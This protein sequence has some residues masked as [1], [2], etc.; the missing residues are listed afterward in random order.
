[1]K[2]VFSRGYNYAMSA[3]D[4]WYRRK[5][6]LLSSWCKCKK[7]KLT[8][9]TAYKAARLMILVDVLEDRIRAIVIERNAA[10]ERAENKRQE[11]EHY[12]VSLSCE[13]FECKYSPDSVIMIV[14]R[15]DYE[16]DKFKCRTCGG[17]MKTEQ[18]IDIERQLLEIGFGAAS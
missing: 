18:E 3:G 2:T 7:E 12:P 5:D 17:I 4:I 14:P 16:P 6:A 8:P 9:G 15:K 1:M 10:K 11:H 13:N